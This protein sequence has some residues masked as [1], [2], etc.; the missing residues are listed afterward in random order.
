MQMEM[1]TF[2]TLF[3]GSVLVFAEFGKKKGIGVLGAIILWLA[4]TILIVDGL[5]IKV[6]EISD[7]ATYGDE[8]TNI[9][10]S[11]EGESTTLSNTTTSFSENWESIGVTTSE[12]ESSER[13]VYWYEEAES[14]W[15]WRF[16]T[17]I[18]LFYWAVGLSLVVYYI[19][20]VWDSQ[21]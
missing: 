12:F 9:T 16:A 4:G 8:V 5:Q 13:M 15:G 18:G 6:G 1:L 17:L 2:L 7:S 14:Y 3:A 10:G 11:K 19:V 20:W 21:K